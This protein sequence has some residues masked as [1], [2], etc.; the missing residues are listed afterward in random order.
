MATF[1]SES[2]TGSRVATRP[3]AIND[4]LG[5]RMVNYFTFFFQCKASLAAF[6]PITRR[7]ISLFVAELGQSQDWRRAR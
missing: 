5:R 3:M 1:L 7:F 4:R 6:F 2:W